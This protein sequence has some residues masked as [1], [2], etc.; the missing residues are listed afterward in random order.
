MPAAML[1]PQPG[2]YAAHADGLPI[3]ELRHHIF[4]AP[5]ARQ[6]RWQNFFVIDYRSSSFITGRFDGENVN[7]HDCSTGGG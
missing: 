5:S 1:H 7:W 3:Q 2:Q 6:L 4:H